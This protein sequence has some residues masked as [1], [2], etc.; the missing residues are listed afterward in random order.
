MDEAI[1]EEAKARSVAQL[2][3]RACRRVNELG[4]A[5][6]RERL[7]AAELRPAHM[8]LFPHIDLEGT[9]LTEVARRAGVTK[10]AVAPLVADLVRLGLLERSPDPHDGR[11][12]LLRFAQRPGLTLLDGLALLGEVD[13]DVA[14]R[15]GTERME[16]LRR[17]LL[18]LLD[19]VD[20]LHAERV[21]E[22]PPGETPEH[23]AAKPGEAC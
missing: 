10:Q 11:A 23:A 17:D 1:W 7:D 8:A 22:Q 5:R 18:A 9:R 16:R 20:A 4:I 21:G 13:A 3:I 15:I 6:L 2:L 19:V 14:Q 12:R